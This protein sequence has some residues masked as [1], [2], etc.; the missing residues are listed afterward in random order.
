MS[1]GLDGEHLRL[2]VLEL[3][4]RIH[5]LIRDELIGLVDLPQE[6]LEVCDL[7]ARHVLR[8]LKEVL[9]VVLADLDVVG[10]E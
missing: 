4:G 8:G 2:E 9:G 1:D 10:H 6:G 3:L 5:F 7:K